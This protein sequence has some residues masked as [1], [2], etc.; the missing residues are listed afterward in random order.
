MT[1]FHLKKVFKKKTS[2]SIHSAYSPFKNFF[3]NAEELRNKNHLKI[4]LI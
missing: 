1:S 2:Q 4:A 3:L